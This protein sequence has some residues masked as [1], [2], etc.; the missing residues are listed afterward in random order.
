MKLH[1]L[2]EFLSTSFLLHLCSGFQNKRLPAARQRRGRLFAADTDSTLDG[3]RVAVVGG[4]PSGLLV[5]HRLLHAGASQVSLYESRPRPKSGE[6]ENRAYALG[7][8]IR[9]RTAI[10]SVDTELW[11]AVK[12]AGCLSER[13]QLHAGPFVIKLRSEKDG[14]NVP[15]YEPSLLT[16]QRE[17]CRVLADELEKRWSSTGKLQMKFDCKVEKLDL[18]A[19][20]LVTSESTVPEAFDLVLGCDGVKSIV[21]A[22]IKETWA[23]FEGTSEVLPG[24][25]KVARIKMPPALDPSAVALMIPKSGSLTAF[26]EPTAEG[27]ACVLF[28]GNNSSDTIFAS[29]NATEVALEIEERFP[30]LKDSGL[31]EAAAQLIDA[32]V[33][34]TASVVKCNI[35]HY[36]DVAALIGDAAHATG[37]VSGQGVNSALVDAAAF[38]ECLMANYDA[39]SKMPSLRKA[40]LEYSKK[41]VP[42]GKALYD[43]SFQPK[44]KS[45]VKRLAASL[46]TILDFLFQ[47]RFGLGRQPLQTKLTTSLDSFADIRRELNGR[48]EDDFPSVSAWEAEITALD[49]KA[50]NLAK[51]TP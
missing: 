18:E 49:A 23:N 12:A 14:E 30:K 35:Y 31:D 46:G 20:R 21:R 5:A 19:R 25:F 29:T 51:S 38:A 15:N 39:S 27:Q 34:S 11:E 2:L 32:T 42:E 41:Q 22:A 1:F 44:P 43:L 17:M 3:L 9:G 26:V 4:G 24:Q 33:P 6:L 37:G 7:V 8:G 13:F 36:S 50:P 16:Y 28:A 40:L 47:G 10:K 45:A 48:F